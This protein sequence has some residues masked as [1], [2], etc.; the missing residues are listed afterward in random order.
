M[1]EFVEKSNGTVKGCTVLNVEIDS[2]RVNSE[3]KA[4]PGINDFLHFR[5]PVNESGMCE[6]LPWFNAK[7][8]AK[9]YK[10]F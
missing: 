2:K 6:A 8:G 1:K 5:F 9:K 7:M 4:V 3:A 10:L